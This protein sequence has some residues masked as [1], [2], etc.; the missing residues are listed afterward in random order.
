MADLRG[1]AGMQLFK[2]EAVLFGPL[3][4]LIELFVSTFS[5]GNF[6]QSITLYAL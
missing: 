2:W 3:Y 5:T 4:L 1:E 6:D